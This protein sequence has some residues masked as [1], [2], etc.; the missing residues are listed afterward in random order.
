MQHTHTHTFKRSEIQNINLIPDK[1]MNIMIYRTP[2]SYVI[3]YRIYFKLSKMVRF[4]AHHAGDHTG[5]VLLS[6][7]LFD[8]ENL[9]L[10]TSC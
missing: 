4:L 2:N 6:S 5:R 9:S 8:I 10:P 3:F 7:E 1:E